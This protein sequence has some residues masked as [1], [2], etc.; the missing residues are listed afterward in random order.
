M[1]I[2]VIQTKTKFYRYISLFLILGLIILRFPLGILMH[3][4]TSPIY[5]N[6]EN[7]IFQNGTYLLTAIL[8]WVNRENLRDFHFDT[9]AILIFI[10]APILSFI[11][12]KTLIPFTPF[13]EFIMNLPW[14]QI[15]ISLILFIML[16][17]CRAIP[18]KIVLGNMLKWVLI[19]V[20]AAILTSLFYGNFILSTNPNAP[21]KASF[22]VGIY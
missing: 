8:I 9:G 16:A 11:S 3:L 15:L 7:Y 4:E 2:K 10:L 17:R 13:P 1:E 18:Y 21:Y 14:L 22:T 5:S 6:V 12:Y 20:I 19:S